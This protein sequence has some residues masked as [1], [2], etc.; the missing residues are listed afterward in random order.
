MAFKPLTATSA[1]ALVLCVAVCL[2]GVAIGAV[3][4]IRSYVLLGS[5]VV[6]T[7]VVATLVRSGL[8]EPRLGAVFLSLLGLAVVAV[9]VFVTTRRDELRARVEAMQRVMAT[10]SP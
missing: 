7:T 3:W 9:M 1:G 6:V 8:A 5:G 4:R 10:W 2:L